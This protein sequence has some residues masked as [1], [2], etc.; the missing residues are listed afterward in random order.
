MRNTSTIV[1]F[2]IRESQPRV[3]SVGTLND[4][5]YHCNRRKSCVMLVAA[6]VP[7]LSAYEWVAKKHRNVRIVT[8]NTNEVAL[9][10]LAQA[11]VQDEK[12]IR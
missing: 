3:R 9:S 1:Q 12:A 10:F 5:N 7:D 4:F 8:V 2:A 11:G 6:G